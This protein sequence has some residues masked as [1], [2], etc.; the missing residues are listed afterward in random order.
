MYS[1][2][3]NDH[4]PKW[5]LVLILCSDYT[6]RSKSLETKT[7]AKN[8]TF[9]QGAAWAKQCADM[10]FTTSVLALCLDIFIYLHL[11]KY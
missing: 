11:T 2:R 10:G 4:W 8:F 1:H 6:F 3:T 9:C 7:S 5:L